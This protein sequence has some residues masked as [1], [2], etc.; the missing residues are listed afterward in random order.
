MTEDGASKARE[1]ALRRLHRIEEE[2]A[3][4]GL[5][6]G[7][8]ADFGA[9]DARQSMDYVAGVTRWRRRLDFILSHYYRGPFDSLEPLLKQIMRLGLYD[10]LYLRTPAYAAVSEAVELAKRRIRTGAGGLVNGVLRSIVRDL[11]EL[12]RPE[13]G[14]AADDLAIL[15]SHPT[16]I[17]RRWL[18]RY[19]MEETEALLVWNNERP[20]YGIRVNT[21]KI[22]LESFLERLDGLGVEWERG[23]YLP[24]F[25][26]TTSVQPLLEARLLQEGYCVV[27]DEGAALLVHLLDPQPGETI[28]DLCSAPGGKA[29]Y[30]AHRMTNAGRVLAVDVHQ[31]RLRLVERGAKQQGYD[32]VEPHV[33]DARTINAGDRLA[34]RVLVDAPCSGLGV[35][36]KRADLRWRR[37]PEDLGE[38]VKL[39]DEILEAG[40]RLVAPGGILVYGTCTLEPEENANRVDAFLGRHEEF[41]LESAS[42][43]VPEE[44]VTPEGF[45]ATLPPRD[46]IDG[47]FGARMRRAG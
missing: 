33:A 36:A 24:H 43:F 6:G 15:H 45:Y 21:D 42:A 12:P 4:I 40:S 14:D 32:I 47:A 19:G 31:G 37:S 5:E 18:E 38:L 9:R 10:I 39:Q 16:W 20:V 8:P 23:H 3:Y 26:R 46:G 25:L 22:A 11:E 35:L 41:E 1:E 29:F 44:L 7:E 2:G 28:V 27:Q 17:V 13:T 34:D 30:A